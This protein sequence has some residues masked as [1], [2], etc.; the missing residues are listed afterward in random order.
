MIN[1]DHLPL[2]FLI[3][4]YENVPFLYLFHTNF[5]AIYHELG[6]YM[7][8]SIGMYYTYSM[9][10]PTLLYFIYLYLIAQS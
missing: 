1:I 7:N 6:T 4:I 8:W 2:S 9:Q 5:E 3:S 10:D